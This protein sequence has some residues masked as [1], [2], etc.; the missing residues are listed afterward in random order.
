MIKHTNVD[1]YLFNLLAE[2]V[3]VHLVPVEGG[4]QRPH[5]VQQAAQRPDVGLEVVAMLVDTLR[6]P[7]T[8]VIYNFF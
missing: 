5:L 6:G 7:K 8:Y 2:W 4:L 1:D 3:E